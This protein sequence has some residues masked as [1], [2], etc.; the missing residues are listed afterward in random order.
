MTLPLQ[1]YTQQQLIR[2]RCCATECDALLQV[3]ARCR[4]TCWAQVAASWD[5]R[6]S[7]PAS[8]LQVAVPGEQSLATPLLITCQSCKRC[9]LQ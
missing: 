4:L 9:G 2:V 3:S 7:N 1:P 5:P 8:P 6:G